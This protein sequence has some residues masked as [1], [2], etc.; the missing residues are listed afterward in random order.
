MRPITTGILPL[1]AFRCLVRLSLYLSQSKIKFNIVDLNRCPERQE[2]PALI[3]GWRLFAPDLRE[4]VTGK[5]LIKRVS[6]QCLH[7]AMTQGLQHEQV[8]LE[9]GMQPG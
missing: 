2:A 4:I 3:L 7:I 8:L 9:L 5:Q 1:V 6:H